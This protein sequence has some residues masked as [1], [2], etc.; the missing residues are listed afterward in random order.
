MYGNGFKIKSNTQRDLAVGIHEIEMSG[1]QALTSL[2]SCFQRI[3]N[4]QNNRIEGSV[5]FANGKTN[6]SYF[7][8]VKRFYIH[9][10][11][12]IVTLAQLKN[13]EIFHILVSIFRFSTTQQRNQTEMEKWMDTKCV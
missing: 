8:H 2:T 3:I 11:L 1:F 13:V 5:Y 4:T 7:I 10:W 9:F 6:E 12:E